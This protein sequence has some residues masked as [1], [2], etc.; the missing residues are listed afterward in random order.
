M[1]SVRVPLEKFS[2]APEAT[3]YVPE[4]VPGALRLSVPALTWTVPTLLK[5]ER[6]KVLAVPVLKTRVPRLETLAVPVERLSGVVLVEVTVKVA[7]ASLMRVLVS[8]EV[9]PKER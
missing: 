7:P 4:S 3:V 2:R 5:L 6:S 9:A 8:L 1:A